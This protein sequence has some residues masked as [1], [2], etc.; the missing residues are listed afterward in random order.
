VGATLGSGIALL[1]CWSQMYF[2]WLKLSGS[3]SFVIDSYP[4][5]INFT[6]I[7]SVWLLVVAICLLAAWL[8]ARKAATQ[9]ISELKNYN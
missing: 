6:D 7:I 4:V 9:S 2:K 8:P 3:G 5:K 1:I